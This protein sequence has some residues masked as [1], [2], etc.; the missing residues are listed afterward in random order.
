MQHWNRIAISTYAQL[1]ELLEA[2]TGLPSSGHIVKTSVKDSEYYQH[3]VSFMGKRV[4]FYAGKEVPEMKQRLRQR[5]RLCSMLAV[6]GC[7]IPDRTSASMIELLDAAGC[8]AGQHA[9][10]VGSHAFAV[11]GNMLGI[12]WQADIVETQDVDLGRFIKLAGEQSIDLQD[13]FTRAGFRAIPALN[14]RHPPTSFSHPSGI[15]VDF[16]TPLTGKGH[17]KPVKLIGMGVHAEELRFLDYLINEPEHGAVITKNGVL[18]RV[19]Q[20]A[21]FALHKCI[22]ATRRPVSQEAKRKKDVTQAE[23]LFNALIENRSFDIQRAWD[24]LPWKEHATRGMNMMADEIRKEVEA[25]VSA[26]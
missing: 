12:T 11:I 10:L 26:V 15:K 8:F 25:I 24:A 14:H 17:E 2:Q 7:N 1:M 3:R 5:M 22:V 4:V 23:A 9:I 18:V 13:T 20:P 19:P 21:R 16:L 6:N